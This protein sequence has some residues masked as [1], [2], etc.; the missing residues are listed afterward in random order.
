MK[1]L[2]TIFLGLALVLP[3]Y[4]QEAEFET[5]EYDDE[6]GEE[7]TN[8]DFIT[9]EDEPSYEEEPAPE[10]GNNKYRPVKKKSD[11]A[12]QHFEFGFDIGAG[13]D[14]GLA[15]LNDVLRK[16]IVFDLSKI[17]Q[18]VP[19]EGTGLNFGLSFDLFMNVKNIPIGEGFWDFG[20]IT[21][22]D[23]GINVNMPKSMFT[24]VAEGNAGQHDT[25][26]KISAAGGIYT[27]IGLTGSAKYE[28]GGR[29]L[30]VGLKPA[31]YTPAA[32]VKP[33]SGI[34]YH[35]YTEKNGKEGLFLDTEGEINVY[36]PTPF[37]NI[38]PGRFI[39]GP[40]GF[41]LSLEGE[42]ALFPFLDVGGSFSHI[43]FAPAVLTN[44]MKMGMKEFNLELAGEDFIGGKDQG[45]K[46][47]DIPKLDFNDP[48]YE[49]NV[50]KEVHRLFRFDV[51]ARYKPFNSELLA[52][53]PNIGF[54]ANVNKGDGKGYFNAGLEARLNLINLFTI[55][56]GSGYQEEVWKQ[57]AGFNLNLRAFELDL[58]AA[59]RDQTFDGCFMGR[60]FGLNL[61]MRF[62]W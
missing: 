41:D 35:L 54:S 27:E 15:G 18:G 55:Y 9:Y 23:G 14:N 13:I 26:G 6:A 56:V 62:G 33:S 5:G 1:K 57:R 34:S 38:E 52:L 25:S 3:L 47:P 48:V 11:F 19:Q 30:Y 28:V 43:P 21:N 4:S 8:G 50:K 45:V 61:G 16:Q 32:Y 12:R 46:E 58:E 39:F 37:D 31:I 40:S 51:Y 7:V 17:A 20:F 2:L 24:L 60:G 49:K 10:P 29:I 36:I 59:L 22:V 53:I 42:Y 44:V